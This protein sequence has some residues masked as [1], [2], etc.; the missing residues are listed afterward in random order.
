[1]T[2]TPIGMTLKSL[3]SFPSLRTG[4][5]REREKRKLSITGL[6][7]INNPAPSKLHMDLGILNPW[8]LEGPYKDFLNNFFKLQ[9]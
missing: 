5:D 3:L 1:M 9:F 6:K 8:W 2:Y 7:K 4:N